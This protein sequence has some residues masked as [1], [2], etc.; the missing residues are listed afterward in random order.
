M[1]VNEVKNGSCDGKATPVI[2]NENES[3]AWVHGKNALGVVV[4][5]F[6]MDLAIRKAKKQGVGLVSAK[7]GCWKLK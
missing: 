5:N 2:I 7:G 4:G 6:S 3:C 1:Y